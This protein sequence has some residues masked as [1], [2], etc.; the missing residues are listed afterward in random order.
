M[1]SEIIIFVRVTN[2]QLMKKIIVLYSAMIFLTGCFTPKSISVDKKDIEENPNL[3]EA[4]PGYYLEF[5]GLKNYTAQQVVDSMKAKQVKTLIGAQVLNACSAVMEKDLGFAHSSTN[6]VKPN[7]GYITLI[8]SKK[9]YGI[10]E[11]DIP[12]DTVATNVNWNI[13]GKDLSNFENRTAL[14]FFIQFLRTDGE[15]INMRYK[16][17]YNQYAE[18]TEKE[19]SN[20]LI[21]HL[22]SL[23]L[24]TE[25]PLA[26]K[27]LK[28]DGN[29]VNRYWALLIMMRT[30]PNDEDIEL[31]LDQYYYDDNRLKSYT[32]YVLRETLKLR[33]DIPWTR[34]SA[35]IQNLLNGA[36][37][38]NYDLIIDFLKDNNMDYGQSS[39][40][41]NPASPILSDYLNAY[42]SSKSKKALD[43]IKKVSSGTVNSKAEANQWLAQQY[44][45][46]LN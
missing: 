18:D 11:K 12:D 8:E 10:I 26:R 45:K 40:V 30:V 38:W 28:S 46:Y 9:G 22:N 42:E 5:I 16:L 29:L 23:N 37:I 36:A 31:L 4:S 3:I 27:T 24:S 32:S 43:F 2:T 35:Q 21:D 33:D 6:Y 39:K 1:F 20:G 14:H 13:E 25:L 15:K 41:F 19:F 34:Y 17:I 44:Q 7:Y